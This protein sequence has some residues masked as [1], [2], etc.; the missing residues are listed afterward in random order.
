MDLGFRAFVRAS[1]PG[2]D[3]KK[4]DLEPWGSPAG[5]IAGVTGRPGRER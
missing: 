3:L 1:F 2:R 5:R 4:E